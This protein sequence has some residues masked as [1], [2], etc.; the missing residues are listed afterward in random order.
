MMERVLEVLERP[1]RL[2]KQLTLA[3]LR[4]AEALDRCRRTTSCRGRERVDRGAPAGPGD[5][6]YAQLCDLMEQ[7]RRLAEQLEAAQAELDAFLDRVREECGFRD[8][9]VLR[10]HYRLDRPWTKI[11]A[12]LQETFGFPVTLRTAHNWHR[13]A[14]REAEK[15]LETK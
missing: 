3:R 2:E 5:E 14:L 11:R 7:Q 9:C 8:Y 10:W 15:L 13:A 1:R 6:R 12:D 4:A